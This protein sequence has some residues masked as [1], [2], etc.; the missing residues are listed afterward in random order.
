M[1]R[2]EYGSPA[3]DVGASIV[4]GSASGVLAL[5]PLSLEICCGSEFSLLGLYMLG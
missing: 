3:V 5:L 1:K 4:E 2:D